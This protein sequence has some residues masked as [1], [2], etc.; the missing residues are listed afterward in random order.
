MQNAIYFQANIYQ[1][2]LNVRYKH[3][4]YIMYITGQ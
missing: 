3:N 1:A 4:L 2:Y